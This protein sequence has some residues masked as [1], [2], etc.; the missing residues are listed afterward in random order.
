MY[1]GLHTT[2]MWHWVLWK[3]ALVQDG[4]ETADIC[5]EFPW[6]GY[7]EVDLAFKSHKG[8]AMYYLI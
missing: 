5:T 6:P 8:S 2:V 1:I 4:R 7:E 3:S